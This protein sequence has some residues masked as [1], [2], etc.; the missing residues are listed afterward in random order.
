MAEH[1]TYRQPQD[2]ETELSHFLKRVRQREDEQYRL[3]DFT[4]KLLI[5]HE[6]QE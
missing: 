5:K 4:N 2:I 3:C 1:Q 6:K